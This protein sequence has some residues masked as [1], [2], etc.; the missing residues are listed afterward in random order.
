MNLKLQLKVIIF[1]QFC[2]WGSWLTTLG[3]YMFVTLKFQGAEIGAVY[4]SLG[5]ASVFMPALLG[6]VAD[7][8]LSAKWVYAICHLVGAI[9]LFIAAGVTTPG[10]MF[11]VILLNS[12]AYMPTLG[13]VNTI[14]YAR[15]QNAGYD[16]VTDFPPIR[17]WGTIGFIL[18]MWAVSF[19]G[20]ELSH[21]QLYI[22]AAL[23]LVLSLFS[24]TLPHMPVSNTQKNQTWVEMLGLN[25]F[26]LFKNKRMAIFFIFSMLLGAELQITNMFGNTFLHSFDSNPLFANSFIVTHASVLMSISQISETVFILAIPFFLGRYGIKNVMLMSIVAWML[27]FGLFAYG[28]PTPFGT[29]LLVLS[30][31]VYG[32]A[33]DFFNISGSVF[34]EKEVNPAIRASAQGMLLMMTN[35][36]GCILGGMASGKVV[37]MY[38]VAGATDWKT[39]WLIFAGYSVV[40]AFAFMAMFKYKHVPQAAGVVQKA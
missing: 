19:S 22:G 9:T 39:V 11:A 1:L 29:V 23:S 37:E 17:I 35:G 34:V 30:M 36:F 12:L 3:S 21:M 31:I 18:A 6:I 25:A 33:F 24:L 27:R 2:L 7:K 13:L 14:S 4:S 32:C 26:A 5:I 28:D 40:L 20:F 15:L 10:A 16:I 38:T 8:W